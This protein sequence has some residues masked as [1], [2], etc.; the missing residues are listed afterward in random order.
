M[1]L[2]TRAKDLATN[3]HNTKWTIPLQ[4]LGDAILC[5][6]IVWKIPYTEID[7]KAYMQQITIYI[8]GER[9]YAKISGDTGPLV[10]PAAHVYIYRALYYLTDSGTDIFTAQLIFIGLYVASLYFVMQTYRQAGVPPWVFPLLS[11]SKRV[12]SIFV[13]RLFNDCFAVAGLFAAVGLWQRRWWTVGTLV[14]SVGVGVKMSLLLC[15]P[16]VGVVLWQAMGRDRA[17]YQAQSILQVQTLIA[18]P[19]IIGGLKSYVT[20]AFEL[21]RTFMFKWT[22]NW[23]F[24]GEERFLGRPFSLLLIAVHLSLLYTFGA[25]RWLAPSGWSVPDAFDKLIEP[26]PKE[27]QARIA[28]RVTP[29]FILTAVLSSMII[30]CLCARSLH[31]QFFVYIAWSTPFLLWKSSMHPVLIYAICMAQEWAWNVYP[32]TN[33]S[34]LVVVSCLATTVGSV[35]IGTSPYLAAKKDEAAEKPQHEHAE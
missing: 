3:P 21:S 13:L 27:E 1:D 17:F 12:H 34:S 19:F 22:V 15:L 9:D 7:W 35:W 29:N 28:R 16:A 24:V 25:G 2:I 18:S 4:L 10:Y 32:S 26:P 23:R 14:Y 33:A 11:L 6:L 8:A 31:Y 5:G 30:G 20:R